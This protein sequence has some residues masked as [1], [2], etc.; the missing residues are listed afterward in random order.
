[1]R[2]ADV[3]NHREVDEGSAAFAADVQYYLMQQP[4][5]LPSRYLYDAL[6]SAL[7][8]AICRLPWYRVT[9][10]ELAL[11]ESCAADIVARA[12]GLRRVI[13]LGPG[14]GEKLV[15]LLE[16]GRDLRRPIEAHLIDVSSAALVQAQR[17]LASLEG[18]RVVAHQASYEEGLGRL[19]STDAGRSLVLFLGSNI[20]NFDPPSAR[21]FLQ[22]IR[23]SMLEGD[24]FL[25]GAD[26]V[27][28][29][30]ELLLAY[31]DPLGVT[32]AFNRN[33][34]CRMN[35]E[36]GADFKVECFG[37]RAIWNGD[38]SR[39]EMHLVVRG[40]QRVRIPAADLALDLQDGETIWTES[41]YKFLP[42]DVSE[43][44]EETGFTVLEQWVDRENGFALT[45][46][47]AH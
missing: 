47:A 12:G 33:I 28:P 15:T 42:P 17:M 43:L 7:F 25:L 9:R 16:N 46:G 26:L 10:A 39:V 27:K 44:L 45:L 23:G 4:R 11:I 20:G 35:Q 34:L 41:S 5:Q 21:E 22:G 6:G 31:D 38:E 24:S 8:D 32:A 3:L 30:H 40:R 19:A 29:E 2:K 36:L 1:M 13:E 18:V 37:H 14:S